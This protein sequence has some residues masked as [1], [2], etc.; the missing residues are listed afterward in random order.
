MLNPFNPTFGVKPERFLG[1]DEVKFQLLHALESPNS[2]WRSTLITGVR[3]SGKTTLLS[4]VKQSLDESVGKLITISLSPTE[5]FLNTLLSLTYDQLPIDAQNELSK[6]SGITLGAVGLA[7]APAPAFLDNFRYQM[8]NMLRII[9]RHGYR[10]IIFVDEIQK[11]TEE[12][13]TFV[14]SYQE[15]LKEKYPIWLFMAGLPNAVS[16]TL[17]DAILSFFRRANRISLPK[18]AQGEIFADYQ[19]AFPDLS[20]KT[21]QEASKFTQGYPYLIQLVGYYLW[22]STK[23]GLSEKKALEHA[24]M[25]SQMLFEQNVLSTVLQ[26]CSETDQELLLV[27]AGFESD[28]KIPVREIKEKFGV[29]KSIGYFSRYRTRL[30]DSG[31]IEQDGYGYVK[32]AMPFLKTYLLELLNEF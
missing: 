14:S 10:L 30:I 24:K 21:L 1:R 2:P 28:R 27:I 29:G 26:D 11:V 20:Q 22:E 7:K 19:E 5:N 31:L 8:E 32:M 15:F 4:D 18:I 16:D 12:L 23:R 3:G 6:I 17:N 9:E 13:K 25:Q